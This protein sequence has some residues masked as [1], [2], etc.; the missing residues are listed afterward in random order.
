M[1]SRLL[2]ATVLAALLALP[3]TATAAD[4]PPQPDCHGIQVTDKAGDS[5]N[6][7][8]SSQAGSPSSDLTAGWITYDPGTG[9]STANIRVA[10]LTAGEVDAPYDGISWEFAFTA[11]KTA[12]YIRGF[13]DIA[14][15]TKFSWG[16]PRAITDDQTAPRAGGPT[17]GKLFEGKDGVIQIDMPLK[18]MGIAPGASLKG[19][20]LEV[21]QWATLPAATPTLPVPFYSPAPIY[22]TAAGKGMDLTPCAAAPSGPLAPVAPIAPSGPAAAPASPATLDVKVTVPK[23]TA[24]KLNRARK[25][26]VSLSGTASKLVATLKKGALGPGGKVV[27]S[28]KLASLKGTGKLVLKLRGKLKKGTYRLDVAGRNADGRSA[29]GAVGVKIR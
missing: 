6:S 9:K 12:R 21:R 22:D 3:V 27:G 8:D 23:T 15:V 19:L 14:G 10:Q 24:K 7:L 29:S 20:A 28:G 25:L 11:G 5:A 4:P 1:M 17:T 13:Q 16:E 2:A 26:T 18:E